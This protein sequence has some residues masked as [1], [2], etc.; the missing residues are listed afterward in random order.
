[1]SVPVEWADGSADGH[2]ALYVLQVIGEDLAGITESVLPLIGALESIEVALNE[3]SGPNYVAAGDL[4]A[5]L[6]SL[7]DGTLAVVSLRTSKPGI[8]TTLLMAPNIFGARL[9]R[10]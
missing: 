3:A 2:A 4:D 8:R 9:G 7:Q 6:R 5:A 10:W 1:M